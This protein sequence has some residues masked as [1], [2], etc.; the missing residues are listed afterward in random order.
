MDSR[1]PWTRVSE[2]LHASGGGFF[3]HVFIGDAD[4]AEGGVDML[5]LCFVVALGDRTDK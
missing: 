1:V 3:G 4:D 2:A 5:R